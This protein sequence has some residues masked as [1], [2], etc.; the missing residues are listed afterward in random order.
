MDGDTTSFDDSRSMIVED[1]I[2][3]V[4]DF[5]DKAG[6]TYGHGTDNAWDESARIVLKCLNVDIGEEVSQGVLDWQRELDNDEVK[7]IDSLVKLRIESRQPLA[8]LINETWFA[9]HRF[10]VDERVIVPRS[11]LGEWIPEL[12]QPW[13]DADKVNN[14]LDLCSGSACIAISCA[15]AFPQSK[16][17]A[18]DLS[19]AAL[20]VAQRNIDDYKLSHRVI[21]NYGDGFEG[22]LQKFDLILCNPPYVSNTRMDS[23]PFEYRQ[24]PDEAFRGGDDGLDFIVPMLQKAVNYL[25]PEGALIVEAG[26]ASNALE[27]RFPQIPFTWLSTEYD[28]MVVFVMSASE[29]ESY[30]PYLY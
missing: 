21:T 11:F 20:Q 7:A 19:E 9:G 1:K 13:I 12:F 4:A 5:L 30:Q 29:L 16:V 3:T 2:D 10:Y 22:L 14:I 15:L 27:D 8:Y 28:E 17:V 18:S 26:S 25:T 23:L 24:E 6:L